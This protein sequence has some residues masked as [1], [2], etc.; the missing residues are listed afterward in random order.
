MSSVRILGGLSKFLP[1]D[2][3]LGALFFFQNIF[4]DNAIRKRKKLLCANYLE[5]FKLS[6]HS[7]WQII[8]SKFSSFGNNSTWHCRKGSQWKGY[9]IFLL[10]YTNTQI[11]KIHL[12]VQKISQWRG[13]SDQIYKIQIQNPTWPC[14]KS[15]RDIWYFEACIL[16]INSIR[17][18]LI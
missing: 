4:K 13:N 6:K 1:T 15:W 12:T 3:Y 2:E 5:R 18:T 7:K 8:K 14:R 10:Q 11:Q 17:Y 16:Q 9:W